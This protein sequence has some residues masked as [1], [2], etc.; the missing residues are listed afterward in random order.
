M[1]YPEIV[2]CVLVTIVIFLVPKMRV[3][4]D[5]LGSTIEKLE[6]KAKK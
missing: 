2:F 5:K 6:D 4:G 3:I 1:T